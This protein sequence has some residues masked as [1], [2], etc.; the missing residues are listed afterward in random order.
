MEE[1]MGTY[2]AGFQMLW[3]FKAELLAANPGSVVEIDV[4]K[5]GGKVYFNRLFVAFKPCLDGFLVGCRPY[6]GIDST[7]LTGKYTGHLSPR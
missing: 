3:N 7:F 2:E 6:L 1:L 5:V 4:K